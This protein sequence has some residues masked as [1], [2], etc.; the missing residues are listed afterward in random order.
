MNYVTNANGTSIWSKPST[1]ESDWLEY[2]KKK[3]GKKADCCGAIDCKSRYNLVGA[4]VQNVFSGRELYITPLCKTCNK[5]SGNFFVDTDLVR[6][7][8]G[9]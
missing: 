2:W 1:G 8:S 5:R 4:H 6:V 3:I 9:L 7:P